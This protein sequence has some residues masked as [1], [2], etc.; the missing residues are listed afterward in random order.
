MRRRDAAGQIDR[1]RQFDNAIRYKSGVT[2]M[3]EY[4]HGLT[5]SYQGPASR[6]VHSGAP[7]DRR[8]NGPLRE[9]IGL[10]T[11]NIFPNL[12]LI[13]TQLE[14]RVPRGPLKT[15]IWTWSFVDKNAAPRPSTRRPVSV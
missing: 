9:R 12:F 3:G 6:A 13:G 2:I 7:T 4:G 10:G 11:R 1:K 5:T 8:R 14:L 15:E